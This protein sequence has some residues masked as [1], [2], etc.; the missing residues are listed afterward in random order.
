M[1]DLLED[2]NRYIDKFCKNLNEE[3]DFMIKQ[4]ETFEDKVYLC[5]ISRKA[6]KLLDILHNK[7]RKIWDQL[8]I[9]TEITL[10]FLNWEEIKAII[11][12]DDAI[13][14]G[15]TFNSVYQQIRLY[16]PKTR[17]VPIC[18]IKASELNLP[19]EKD[20]LST[21]VERSIGHYFVNCLSL[22]F[23]KQC[24]PFEVEF[25][26]F[27]VEK[28]KEAIFNSRKLEDSLR[29]IGCNVYEVNNHIC[30]ILACRQEDTD[31]SEL[32]ID[33]S[34][35]GKMCKKIRLYIKKDR[36]LVSS[37]C[38]YPIYQN[39]LESNSLF[40]NTVYH[41]LWQFISEKINRQYKDENYFKSLCTALNFIYSID[42]FTDWQGIINECISNSLDGHSIHFELRQREILLLFGKEIAG[43]MMK[44]YK[45][46][47]CKNKKKQLSL[48]PPKVAG[49]FIEN[50]YLPQGFEF[51]NYYYSTQNRISKKFDNI[52]GILQAIFYVQNAMLDKKNRSFFLIK[53][54]RLKYGHTFGSLASLLENNADSEAEKLKTKENMHRW[55]DARIDCATIVPQYIRNK[56]VEGDDVWI[57]VFR[58]GENEVYFI[59]HWA[60][61]CVMILDEELKLT[62]VEMIDKDYFV[63]LVTWIY[64]KFSL[65]NYFY[66]ESHYKYENHSYNM[67]MQTET[68]EISVYDVLL[69]L[70]ITKEPRKGYVTLNEDL[71][72]TELKSST[73]LPDKIT[74]A[75]SNYLRQLHK[76]NPNINDYKYYVPFFDAKLYD[77]SPISQDCD[78]LTNL[79]NFMKD[80][81]K[82]ENIIDVAKILQ[83]SSLKKK[84][85]VDVL[86][87][88]THTEN[89]AE[90]NSEGDNS[91]EKLSQHTK[92]LILSTNRRGIIAL[93]RIINIVLVGTIDDRLFT[94]IKSI[95]VPNVKFL[96]DYVS[97]TPN[98]QITN[99][100]LF[101][102]IMERGKNVWLF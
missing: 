95:E 93:L 12:V 80:V 43:F 48:A 75:I 28:S 66:D 59:S 17:I 49:L 99:V 29:D 34:D 30:H 38:A 6:P 76:E 70:E 65:C 22:D 71:L 41:E 24:T 18:C 52:S 87:E 13:Y 67:Y 60:R 100:S 86:A 11:L 88:A 73:I 81:A 20:L 96:L 89:W 77:G 68:D 56:N 37:I 10:P 50:E 23:R 101:N 57:R 47:F 7:L 98:N 25:P 94:F 42:L 69:N 97:G 31:V 44:W 16:S 63:S 46:N 39:I 72:D 36:L 84:V 45:D 79:F 91:E 19:F 32:G 53:N 1:M 14:Y 3:V 58:S 102:R 55:I 83:F 62:G 74:D 4:K 82:S 21:S 33:I 85:Y 54:E 9:V 51:R 40:S 92:E 35:D 5:A 27:N 78:S 2:Y 61:L 90:T 26:V 15:S 64:R 8:I